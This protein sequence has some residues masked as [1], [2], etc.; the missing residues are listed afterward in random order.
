M[1]DST[2]FAPDW[3]SP[4]GD[5]IADLLEERGWTHN[6]LAE[7]S[8]FTPKHVNAL[9]KG[10]ATISPDA[11][12]RLS[13]VLGSTTDFWLVREAHYRA[14][15]ERR[16]VAKSLATEA[17]WLREIP[18]AW[19]KRQG[20]VATGSS[21]SER[22]EACLRYF[23]VATVDAWRATYEVPLAAFRASPKF[24]KKIGAVASW[25]RR[26]EREATD[27]SCA[28]YDRAAFKEALGEL[29]GFTHATHPREFVPRL[30]EQCAK[31]GV[32]VVFAP[33]PEGCPASGATR[34]LSPDK[35][36]LLLSLRHNTNDHLWF[37]FFHEAAHL[38]LHGKKMQFV[39]GLDGLDEEAEAEAD[40]FARDWLISPADARRLESLAVQH[41]GRL[42]AE[43]VT[44]FASEIG[45][46][47]GIVVGRMQKEKWLRWTHLNSLK[48]RY[49]WTDAEERKAIDDD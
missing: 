48:A 27:V 36:M 22:V 6:E 23:G 28:P 7:R 42:S 10:T 2:N 34:W 17:D 40:R 15:M 45:I 16:S 4:P 39:D 24:E 18:L 19:M 49:A 31:R 35:A 8:G 33:A 29:R 44:A 46:A 11:A 20:W 3:V 25:L 47:P 9:L 41:G 30:I 37:T 26:G 12:E 5:T 13:R 1:T 21:V 14:A 38:L 32:A 43:L